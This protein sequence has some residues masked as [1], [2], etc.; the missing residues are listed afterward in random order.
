VRGL[1]AI[2]PKTAIPVHYN[3]YGIFKSPLDQFLRKAS[4]ADLPCDIPAL[5]HGDSFRF[6]VNLVRRGT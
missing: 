4:E 6:Q 3:D 1:E 5:V 2:R